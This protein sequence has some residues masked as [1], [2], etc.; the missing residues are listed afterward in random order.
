MTVTTIGAALALSTGRSPSQTGLVTAAVL[1]GQLSIGWSNDWIDAPRD[2]AA[3]RTDKPIPAAQAG[4]TGIGIA[5]V[6]ALIACVPLSIAATSTGWAH[7]VAVAMGWWYNLHAKRT[8]VSPLPFT[9]AFALLVIFAVPEP[10]WQLVAVGALLGTA[11]H[12][13]NVLPDLA[14]DAA[15]GVTGLPH[16]L[17]EQGSTAAA[18]LCL[19]AATA[20]LLTAFEPW[21]LAIAAL[22]AAGLAAVTI[23]SRRRPFLF[24]QLAALTNVAM[25][26]WTAWTT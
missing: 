17:G 6:V 9:I 23:P 26:L 11:A 22:T 1:T 10:A 20:V 13:T 7:L 14:E 21:W 16:R 24:V 25:L 3:A 2:A 19:A 15:T 5:A 8:L 4:S 18:L 12:I